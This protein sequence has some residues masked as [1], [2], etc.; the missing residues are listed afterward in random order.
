MGFFPSFSLWYFI[1]GLPKWHQFLNIDFVSCYFAISPIRSSS[2]LVETTGFSLNTI[3]SSA[4]NDSFTSSFPIRMPFSC[5]ITVTRTSST[6]LNK[7]G[8]NG[9]P[10]LV[11]DLKGKAFSFCPL[12]VMLSVGFSYMAFV[13]LRYAPSIL[14]L[15]SVFILNGWYHGIF[16]QKHIWIFKEKTSSSEMPLFMTFFSLSMRC[17]SEWMMN[18]FLWFINLFTD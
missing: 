9:H 1:F 4:N 8:K 7:S 15:L 6:M 18:V 14:S 17:S 11:P 2:F 16:Y 10:Y 12:S 3:M 5:L 13:L